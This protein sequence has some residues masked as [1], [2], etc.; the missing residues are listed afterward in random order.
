MSTLSALI[1]DLKGH[2]DAIEYIESLGFEEEDNIT[3]TKTNPSIGDL[4]EDGQVSFHI[5]GKDRSGYLLIGND[6]SVKFFDTSFQEIGSGIVSSRLSRWA[7]RIDPAASHRGRKKG[8]WPR[9]I[10]RAEQRASRTTRRDF[11]SLPF[12]T[13]VR[14]WKESFM[15]DYL[16]LP[17]THPARE[18]MEEIIGRYTS[19]LR[20]AE[21]IEADDRREQVLDD[22]QGRFGYI[23]NAMKATQALYSASRTSL[24]M[25]PHL[26][27]KSEMTVLVP[28]A[29][30][31]AATISTA[32][33]LIDNGTESVNMIMTDIDPEH[34]DDLAGVLK[35]W[36]ES[37]PYFEG[38]AEF[39]EIDNRSDT[40]YSDSEDS[41]RFRCTLTYRGK[42]ITIVYNLNDSP[43]D[44]YFHPADLKETDMIV[45]HDVF[46]DGTTDAKLL[47]QIIPNLPPDS[48]P[49]PIV[50]TN[51]LDM[52]DHYGDAGAPSY[53]RLAVLPVSGRRVEG[54]YGCAP[55]F[56]LRDGDHSFGTGEIGNRQHRSAIII[57]SKN[58]MISGLDEDEL[59]TML[60]FAVLAGGSGKPNRFPMHPTK[61]LMSIETD[62]TKIDEF[63][64]ILSWADTKL[65]SLSGIDAEYFILTTARLISIHLQRESYDR[66][67]EL[68]AAI[69][70][71]LKS[72][73]ARRLHELG[74][75]SRPDKTTL[76]RTLSGPYQRRV[77][78]LKKIDRHIMRLQG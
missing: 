45:L 8:R 31:H 57:P 27:D 33:G 44:L 59:Q 61:V 11:Q 58:P 67:D 10:D 63:E 19:E 17:T 77:R 38:D 48:A 71:S 4:V 73:L 18:F 76:I 23:F 68:L 1:K 25:F 26:R 75:I 51:E 70:E 55:F 72:S 60:R 49:I 47:E 13:D 30:R 43:E 69:P 2:R 54:S 65:E 28:A 41:K 37:N 15:H 46:S 74:L 6:G 22:I 42:P 78:L 50:L 64:R 14:T 34:I 9:Q 32:M 5:E 39:V 36:I 62:D 52:F 24:D 16:H 3:P 53:A 21:D 29:G 40:W 12:V 35:M 7:A 66:L 20:A 56:I